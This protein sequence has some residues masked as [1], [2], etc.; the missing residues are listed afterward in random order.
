MNANA[1]SFI[2]SII[3]NADIPQDV[4][5]KALVIHEQMITNKDFCIDGHP[6]E[7]ST[8]QEIREYVD[9]G[10]K[11]KAV[12]AFWKSTRKDLKISKLAIEREFGI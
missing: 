2:R 3:L 9:A 12:K 10:Q 5:E 8:Y 11:I 4:R 7:P 1:K 6:V